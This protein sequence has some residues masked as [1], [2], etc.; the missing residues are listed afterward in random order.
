MNRDIGAMSLCNGRPYRDDG[1]L[2]AYN[3]AIYQYVGP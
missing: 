1:T 2:T 3:G